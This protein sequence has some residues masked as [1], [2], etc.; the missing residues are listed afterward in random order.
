MLSGEWGM[1][2]DNPGTMPPLRAGGSNQPRYKKLGLWLRDQIISGKYPADSRVPSENQLAARFGV[3]RVTARQAIQIL[4]REG[5]VRR[6][7]GSGTYVNRPRD[8]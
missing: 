8:A 1:E 3:S 4:Q 7:R 6:I 5:L 2:I